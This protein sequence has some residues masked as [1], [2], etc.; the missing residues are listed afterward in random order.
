M[1]IAHGMEQF[2]HLRRTSPDNARVRVAGR[3]HAKCC[4]QVQIFLPFRIPNMHAF[5]PLPD[6]RPRAISL[7]ERDIARFVCAEQLKA[8]S[9]IQSD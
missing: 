1:H 9:S 5:G 2:R 7:D 6:N 8:L 3:R 4:R